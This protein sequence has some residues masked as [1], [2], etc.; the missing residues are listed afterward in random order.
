MSRINTNV[1][2]LISS[3]ILNDNNKSLNKSLERLSTGLRINRGADDPA[4]LIASENLRAEKASIGAAI[5]NAERASSIISTAEGALTEISSKLIKL[6]ELVS[7]AASS[8]GLTPEEVEANQV[9]VDGIVNSINRIASQTSFQ[10]VK[11]LDGSQAIQAS[12]GGDIEDLQVH[13]A[14]LGDAD[15]MDLD[16][17]VTAATT[18]TVAAPAGALSADQTIEISGAKGSHVFSFANG[19]TLAEVSDAIN[20]VKEV[21]GVSAAAG[22]L[23]SIEYG[24]D[25]FVRVRVLSG[26][27]GGYADA[28]QE[29]TDSKVTVNGMAATVSGRDVSLRTSTLSLDFKLASETDGTGANAQT[30]TITGGGAKFQLSPNAGMAGYEVIGI[31]SVAAH[32]L[33]ADAIG[34]LS[35][36][37]TGREYN[38]TDDAEK[39][40][41]IVK[42]AVKQV[43]SMRGRLGSFQTDSLGSTINSLNVA[44]ENVT[45]AESA[46]RDTDFAAETA[47]MTRSQ[48]LV[49]AA[50]S[51]LA[52]ANAAPQSVLGLLR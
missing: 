23:N 46:I 39:A 26:A 21:T 4:G 48:I 49:N 34:F 1:T 50:T 27:G 41:N 36:I 47:N 14:K 22:A 31:N 15:T 38:L 42:S 2:S 7:Q 12:G 24:A 6:Q 16:M 40:M 5:G 18:A 11:L 10:G 13:S 8:G 33:G 51:V 44:M 37:T 17:T 19:A 29:G 20:A 30:I 52:M 3:R 45:A 32:D 35:D 9:Q 25:Q 28:F 43:A